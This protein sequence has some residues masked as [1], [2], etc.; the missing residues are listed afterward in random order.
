MKT[1]TTLRFLLAGFVGVTALARAAA[2]Q[3]APKNVD[4]VFSHPEKFT[5]V[6][7]N[8]MDFENERGGANV[9]PRLQELVQ[10]QAAPLLPAGQ[11]LTVTFTDID[12]AG[13]FEPWR[14]PQFDDIRIVK[15]IYIPRIT[16]SFTV[17]DADGKVVKQGDRRLVDLAFQTRI[18]R[19][20][21]NDPLRYEKDMLTDWIHDEFRK[22]G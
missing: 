19:A 7:E 20:F 12:L 17:T 21:A 15:D 18:T 6:K 8:S 14:G 5:D 13:D 22:Q 2:G 4:V 10:N 3:P 9:F 11:K 16:L 1:S